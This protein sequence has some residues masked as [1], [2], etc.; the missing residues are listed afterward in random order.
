M[1]LPVPLDAVNATLIAFVLNTVAVPI[2]GA[3][4]RVS[5]ELDE[6]DDVDVPPELVEVTTNV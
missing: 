3:F 6:G 2:S 1:R 5:I 4:G